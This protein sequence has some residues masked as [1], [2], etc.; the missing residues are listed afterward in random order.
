[1]ARRKR[2]SRDWFVAQTYD[3]AELETRKNLHAVGYEAEY[4]LTRLSRNL[5]GV[6]RVVSLFPSYV[7]VRESESWQGI[8]SVRGVARL[9]MNEGCPSRVLDVDVQFFLSG[10]VDEFGYYV[11]P[12]VRVFRPGD[13]VS[14][15]SGR[16]A[17]ISGEFARR[18]GNARAEIEYVMFGRKVV[19]THPVS[20][21]T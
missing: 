3:Y 16:F 12:S 6:R 15:K 4:P 17:G 2:K 20:D 5:D 11:D 9:L 14:P 19:H 10:S 18:L 7:F 1:M 21:L 8:C 13:A